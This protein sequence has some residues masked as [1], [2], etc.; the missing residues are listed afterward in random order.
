[1][2]IVSV[3]VGMPRTVTREGRSLRTAGVKQEVP[4]ALLRLDG[5][6]GDGQAD[7]RHHGGS[8]R[9][10]C[11]Y[12][13]EHYEWWKA[14]HGIVMVAGDFSENLTVTGLREAEIRIGDVC[15]I[16]DALAQVTLPRD[17][18]ATIERINAA[19]SLARL[20]RESG[21]CGFHM[22]TIQEGAVR[23][24]DRFEIVRPHAAGISVAAALDLYHGRS[25]DH[26]LMK[27]LIDMPEFAE[28]GKREL[29]SRLGRV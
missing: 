27:R 26:E 16:G 13:A 18:C 20:A 4:E 1:M 10:V 24:G 21:R 29:A 22:R 7:R 17:P 19:S 8:D 9:T 5:F 2:V 15:R 23:A 11:V 25:M 3:H 12:P 14:A 28:E 6:E